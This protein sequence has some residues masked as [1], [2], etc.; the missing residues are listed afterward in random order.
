MQGLSVPRLQITGQSNSI[1]DMPHEKT[2]LDKPQTAAKQIA[3]PQPVFPATPLKSIRIKHLTGR[4]TLISPR[5]LYSDLVTP[6]QF[7]VVWVWLQANPILPCGM[8]LP[9]HTRPAVK[10]VMTTFLL[11]PRRVGWASG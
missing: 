2:S 7:T 10:V 3:N 8:P 1:P 9:A 5:H 4:Q 6:T 11:R